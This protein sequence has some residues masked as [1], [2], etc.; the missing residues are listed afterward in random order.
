ME[1]VARRAALMTEIG[2][3]SAVAHAGDADFDEPCFV[4][5]EKE[6]SESAANSKILRYY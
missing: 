1:L 4:V 5:D 6:E 2:S 3:A